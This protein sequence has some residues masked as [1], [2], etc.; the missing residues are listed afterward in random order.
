M[1]KK[2]LVLLL[3]L[4]LLAMAACGKEQSASGGEPA[5]IVVDTT[6][7]GQNPV[8]NF[9]GDYQADR[10]GMLVEA[11]GA[12][13]AKFTV[14]WG[15]S[16]WETSEWTMSGRLDTETLTVNY[17]N[18]TRVDRVYAADGKVE[19]ETVAYENG[20]GSVS[21]LAEQNALTWNDAQ[22]HIADEITFTFGAVEDPDY[23]SGFT[24]MDREELEAIARDICISY[25]AEDWEGLSKFIRYPITVNGTELA[26]EDAFLSYMSDKTVSEGDRAEIEKELCHDMFY[27]GQGLCLG[28]GEIWLLDPSYMT[29]EE[30]V[31]Q[32]IAISGIVEK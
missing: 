20:S 19:S 3:A 23:Y 11:E 25:L 1:S 24:A 14:V 6:E 8:M 4:L 27:N 32:I 12:E 16:A 30:P 28:G 26:D 31:I 17:D 21:F 15:S 22:E 29:D 10:A 9:I 13:N 7:D 5:E 18:C 2:I